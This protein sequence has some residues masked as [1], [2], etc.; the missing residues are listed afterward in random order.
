VPIK[1][2]EHQKVARSKLLDRG[3]YA[4]FM[5][6]GTGK[7]LPILYH[8]AHLKS[9]DEIKT[10]IIVAPISTMGAWTRD[11]E[12]LSPS[13]KAYLKDVVVIN[14][15]KVWRREHIVNAQWDC[16]ILD[17]SH[18]I[19]HRTS[20]RSKAVRQMARSS[21][22]R[23]ILTGTPMSNGHLEEYWAQFD[24]LNPIIFGSYKSFLHKYCTL[25]PIFN[26]PYKYRSIDEL[27][28]IIERNS[29]RITKDECLDLPEKMDDE[30]I[31]IELKEKSKYKQMLDN[32]IK[33]LEI[34]AS[35]PLVRMAKLRQLCSGFIIDEDSQ[36]IELKS[37]KLTVL[38]ELIE[39]RGDKKTVI[40]AEF[41]Y[42]IKM[43]TQLLTKMKINH[44]TLDGAQKDKT[45][46]KQ[47]QS[48]PSIQAIVCQY[49]TANAGIDLYASDT[50]IFYEPTLS[51]MINDQAKDRIHRIGQH[52]PCSYYYLITHGTIEQ[53]IY[54]TLIKGRD[55]G[56]EVLLDFIRQ[57]RK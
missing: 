51:S 41:K 13:K 35:N 26:T 48:D 42:S 15:D 2:Y 55:F 46:W 29:Y 5:E 18:S 39:S 27:Q 21:K 28:E 22:Y 20:K 40:F 53:K 10:C 25:H 16:I 8:I 57:E 50:I 47:F 19:K 1:L 54:N 45:I 56:K 43:I 14:Y 38:E 31:E 6:Q 9:I 23:Y 24:F 52:Q 3:Y 49:Q 36:A 4:L 33:E 30:I 37:D 17:E 11:I 44:V 34:E 7:T 32:F 12:K